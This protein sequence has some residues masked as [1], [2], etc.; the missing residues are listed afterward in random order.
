MI[1]VAVVAVVA[2][3]EAAVVVVAAVATLLP[4]F[5]HAAA[6]AGDLFLPLLV[7]VGPFCRGKHRHKIWATKA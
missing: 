1:V 5:C 3:V 2:V 6:L 4:R 7:A